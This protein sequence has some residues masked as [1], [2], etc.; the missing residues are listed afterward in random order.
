M[1]RCGVGRR[2]KMVYLGGRDEKGGG[3]ALMEGEDER[4]KKFASILLYRLSPSIPRRVRACACGWML[5]ACVCA[6]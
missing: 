5:R 4:K 2:V 6:V 3:R 1:A